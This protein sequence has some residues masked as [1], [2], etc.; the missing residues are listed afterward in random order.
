MKRASKKNPDLWHLAAALLV[1]GAISLA[2]AESPPEEQRASSFGEVSWSHEL[3]ARHPEI[4]CA[5]CHHTDGPASSDCARCSDCHKAEKE[6]K[7]DDKAVC[8]RD[9]FHGKCKGCH[10]A[11]DVKT[12]VRCRQCHEPTSVGSRGYAMVNEQGLVI[13]SHHRHSRCYGDACSRCHHMYDAADPK[14]AEAGSPKEA[15]KSCHEDDLEEA[16]HGQCKTC[17][18]K[19]KK[20][21]TGCGQCH[22]ED[23]EKVE[24]KVHASAKGKVRWSHKDHV[25]Q[26]GAECVSCHHLEDG[27]LPSSRRCGDCHDEEGEDDMP[28]ISDAYHEYCISCHKK[29]GGGPVSC[30]DCHEK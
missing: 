30:E 13:W 27:D 17:H 21:P 12:A 19:V 20:G 3:H 7:K 28:S 9:A 1:V 24:E 4:K 18:E 8:A 10:G 16:M 6:G 15:C 26:Y 11:M 29:M 25:D 2:T 5:A 23:V 22:A 14:E